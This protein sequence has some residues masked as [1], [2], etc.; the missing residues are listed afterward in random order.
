MAELHWDHTIQFTNHLDQAISLFGDY[1]F[2]VA[3]GGK[4]KLWGTSNAL[5]YFDLSYIEFL[6]IFDWKLA[7]QADRGNRVTY[8]AVKLL[9]ETQRL[10]FVAIRS[11]DI[12]ENYK[13]FKEKGVHVGPMMD[14]KRLDTEGRLIQ[15]KMFTIDDDIDGLAYPFF[16]QWQGSDKDRLVQLKD[17]GVIKTHPAGEAN[18]QTAVFNVSRPEQVAKKWSELLHLDA[19]IEDRN[20][21]IH[22]AD[23]TFVFERGNENRLDRLLIK[24]DSEKL[25]GSH[26]SIGYGNYYFI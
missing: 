26:I 7:E 20:P 22:I 12:Q 2:R 24:T 18:V 4:H 16:I 5:L 14:G 21:V 25:K 8:D 17:S 10:N 11:T 13:E 1:G 9:P 19:V 23:K 3:E 6:T 15:W